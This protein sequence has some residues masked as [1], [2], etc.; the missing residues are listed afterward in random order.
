MKQML[1][2]CP[3]CQAGLRISALKCP[4]CGLELRNDFELSPFEQLNTDQYFFLMNFLKNRGNLK[5]LQNELKISYPA[6]KKKLDEV[7]AALGFNVDSAAE[8]RPEVIDMT[9]LFVDRSSKKASEIIKGKLM[10]HGGHITVY[11]LRGLPCEVWCDADGKSFVCDKLPI[12]PPYTYDVF[13][14]IVELLRAQGGSARKG[15]GRNYRFGDPEC[16]EATVVGAVA[17]YYFGKK[18]GESVV[19]PI[20]VFA[21]I[22]E[23]AGIAQNERGELVL[24][25]E[26][27]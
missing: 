8:T 12:K 18:N 25:A 1:S 20:F 22:L 24:S 10:E 6:A 13:D 19:D 17:K 21:A 23:W 3:A 14:I 15:N 27:R 2:T 26:Y 16:D 11:T 9:N 7:L 4:E 5:N